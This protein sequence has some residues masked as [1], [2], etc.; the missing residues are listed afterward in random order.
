MWGLLQ[1]SLFYGATI[2]S[3]QRLKVLPSEMDQVE[4]GI[5]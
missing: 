2:Q 4:S 1:I 5:N 3:K